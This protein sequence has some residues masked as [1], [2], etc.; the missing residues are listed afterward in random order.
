MNISH[1]ASCE[2]SETYDDCSYIELINDSMIEYEKLEALDTIRRDAKKTCYKGPF[3]ILLKYLSV[4][5]LFTFTNTP[6]FWCSIC[7]YVFVRLLKAQ[8]LAPSSSEG[9]YFST[10]MSTLGTFMS[11]A[12]TFF[13]SNCYQRFVA[14]YTNAM[15]AQGRVFDI[16]LVSKSTL[17]IEEQWRIWRYMNV[18]HTLAYVGLSDFYTRSNLFDPLVSKYKLLTHDEYE[19]IISIGIESGGSAYRE[20]LTWVTE[21]L[22]RLNKKGVLCIDDLQ[23]L[24]SLVRAFR[25]SC[26]SLY[27]YVDQ[28]IPMV[29]I[30]QS[31]VA[32]TFLLL[33]SY[34]CALSLSQ[35]SGNTN[36]T[37]AENIFGALAVIIVNFFVCGMLGKNQTCIM[38][39]ETP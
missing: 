10:P 14:I 19:R 22:Y 28:P 39:F 32:Y 3:R 9:I 5:R 20:V 23:T 24:I 15:S 33:Y 1:S 34:Y 6:I 35:L 26:G 29:Y 8:N 13:T 4:H 2:F 27:D 11:F 37:I 12:V 7:L 30:V 18:A 16:A 21:S 17:P 25:G 31:S 36:V 38:H